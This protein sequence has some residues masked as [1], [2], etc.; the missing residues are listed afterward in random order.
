MLSPMK[1]NIPLP[2]ID[3]ETKIRLTNGTSPAEGRLEVRISNQWLTVCDQM[4]DTEDADV[5][6]N[7]LGHKQTGQ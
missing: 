5:V 6:C 4:F 1:H 7:M 3:P 2:R